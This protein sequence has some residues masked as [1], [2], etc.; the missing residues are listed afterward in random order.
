MCK[1]EK[2]STSHLFIHCRV[3][4]GIWLLLFSTFG[5]SWML[6]LVVKDILVVG[7]EG[8]YV[9]KSMENSSAVVILVLMEKLESRTI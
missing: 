6:L 1:W 3:V 4:H 7:M 8:L 5:A 9:G 2:G